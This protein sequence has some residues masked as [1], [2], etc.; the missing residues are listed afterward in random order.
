LPILLI[1]VLE[2]K[3]LPEVVCLKLINDALIK[4]DII[5]GVVLLDNLVE[6]II[7][8][9]LLNAINGGLLHTS[10]INPLLLKHLCSK[11]ETSLGYIS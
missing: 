1:E 10:R 11:W 2:E 8:E 6:L 7:S 5:V 9:N 3:F 4:W